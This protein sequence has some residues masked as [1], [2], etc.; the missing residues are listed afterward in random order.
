MTL[1]GRGVKRRTT[2]FRLMFGSWG[3]CRPVGHQKHMLVNETGVGD[4][5]IMDW[6]EDDTQPGT[7][8]N[9]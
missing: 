5:W 9:R 2:W 3:R 8:R 1:E 7:P 4:W 6:D